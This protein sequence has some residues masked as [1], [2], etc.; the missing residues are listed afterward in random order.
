[1]N[2]DNIKQTLQNSTPSS[3]S[4]QPRQGVLDEH[5]HTLVK[6]KKSYLSDIKN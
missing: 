4:H 1:M 6:T 3:G 5:N 2:V